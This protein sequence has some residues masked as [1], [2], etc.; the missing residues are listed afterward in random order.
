MKL[1]AYQRWLCDEQWNGY[2]LEHMVADAHLKS[3][4]IG[5]SG[6]SY[7]AL[8][9]LSVITAGICGEA[10]EVSEH[11]KKWIRD[12]VLD[13]R[14]AAIELGDVLAYLTWLGASIGY[15]LEDIAALNCEKLTLRG[16]PTP[17]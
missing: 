8:R 11:F 1:D 3:T 16:K 6:D 13:K 2:S 10:G 17:R 5:V 4:G 9:S 12:G 15:S 7:R 14:E